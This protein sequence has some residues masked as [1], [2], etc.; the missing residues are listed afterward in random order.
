MSAYLFVWV[1]LLSWPNALFLSIGV[2]V[3]VTWWV[4]ESAR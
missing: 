1:W 4:F 2:S 3:G